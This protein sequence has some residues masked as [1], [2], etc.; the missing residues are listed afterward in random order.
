MWF[1][2][3]QGGPQTTD[4]QVVPFTDL[5]RR[6]MTTA[7]IVKPHQSIATNTK[8][9]KKAIYKFF[10][11]CGRMGELEGIFVAEPRDVKR[12]VDSGEELYFGEVLGKHSEISG[13]VSVENFTFV[14]DKE[15]I[16][17]FFEIHGMATGINPLSYF[18]EEGAEDDINEEDSG[19]DVLSEDH[20]FEGFPWN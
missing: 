11:D 18:E 9:M 15:E 13:V 16:V 17:N 2:W 4:R 14:T 8:Q 10:F 6:N 3:L 20:S 7:K 12:L 5:K 1:S 19:G